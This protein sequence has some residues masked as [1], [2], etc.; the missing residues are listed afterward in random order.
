MDLNKVYTQ[1][2]NYTA[3]QANTTFLDAPAG[4]KIEVLQV[5][6]TADGDNTVSPAILIGFHDST[7]PTGSGCVFAHPGVAAGGGA[8]RGGGEGILGTGGDGEKILVTCDE[9]TTGSLDV[10]ISYRLVKS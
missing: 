5:M 7:T 8:S 10:V 9:P 2:A 1:R 6:V 3:A 4:L